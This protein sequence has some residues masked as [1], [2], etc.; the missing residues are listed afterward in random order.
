MGLRSILPRIVATMAMVTGMDIYR[1]NGQ[2]ANP[3][4]LSWQTIVAPESPFPM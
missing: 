1:D 2:R 3:I 4:I